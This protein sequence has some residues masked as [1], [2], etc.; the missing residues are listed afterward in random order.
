MKVVQHYRQ[1]NPRLGVFYV[2]FTIL[3][4]VLASG[5]AWR[6]LVMHQEYRERQTKQSQRRVVQPGPRGN[7]YDYSGRLLVGN[8]PRFSAVVYLEELRAELTAEYI[9]IKKDLEKAHEESGSDEKFA[10]DWQETLWQARENVLGRYLGEINEILGTDHQ[11]SRRDIRRH[12]GERLLMPFELVSDLPPEDYARLIEQ[13]PLGSKV[14]I[15]TD[16]ARDYPHGGAAA[17]ALGYVR[18]TWQIPPV[19]LPGANLRTYSHKGEIGINGLEKQF[20]DTLRGE[21]GGEIH[22]VDNFQYQYDEPI[23]QVSAKQG[24]SIYTSLDIDLQRAAERA[25]GDRTGAVVAILVPTGEVVVLA[26]KPGYDLNAFSPSLSH[27][28]A[29]AITES[30][31][32][33]NRATRGLYPPG[34]TFKLLTA[35]AGLRSGDIDPNETVAGGSHFRVGNRLFPEHT[36]GPYYD[37]DL[38][39]AIEKSSNVYFYEKGIETGI[40]TIA[41]EARR[42]GLHEPTGIELP[43][44]EDGMLIPDRAW[45]RETRGYGWVLGDTANVSIGQGD[46]LVTPLQ[47]AAFTASLARG[48]TRTDVTII[49]R[50]PGVDID[51]GGEPIGLTETQFATLMEGMERVV[52]PT[53]TGRHAMISGVRIGGKT[54]TAQVKIPGKNLTLAW[55]VGFAPVDDPQIAVAV[56]VEGLKPGDRYAGG[57]TAAPVARAVLEAFF[58]EHGEDDLL[59]LRP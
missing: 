46:L 2:V 3:F 40:E 54:G 36:G 35:V 34:S 30:G 43:Y 57:A 1:M 11:L 55:F 29:N 16:T 20:E 52:S 59:A 58:R 41:A 33:L 12:F 32:W 21:S 13:L 56:I 31:G 10:F 25:L 39:M 8:R 7:I 26:S 4:G 18:G 19:D 51:H 15:Y 45:K 24:D 23:A 49:K 53:G 27:E 38:P 48:E 14:G 9:A 47:M 6:Q 17:H 50:D 28:T 44:E 37:I 42:F 22:L 5:L